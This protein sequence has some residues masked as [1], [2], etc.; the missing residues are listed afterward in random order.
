MGAILKRQQ[1]L[2][3][4]LGC[5]ETQ[6]GQLVEQAKARGP[7]AVVQA[8]RGACAGGANGSPPP[9]KPLRVVGRTASRRARSDPRSSRP[10]E[11]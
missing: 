2:G 5:I 6:L 1:P 4:F 9:P 7:I 11:R 8:P 3:A 10:N